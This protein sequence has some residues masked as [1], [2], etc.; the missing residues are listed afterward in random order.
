MHKVLVDDWVD[1]PRV[2]SPEFL[3]FKLRIGR[4]G[5]EG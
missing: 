1:Y 5:A 4:V 2:S 3:L